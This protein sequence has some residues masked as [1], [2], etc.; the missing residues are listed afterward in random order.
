M[1]A[2]RALSVSLLFAIAISCT[3]S[4]PHVVPSPPTHSVSGSSTPRA[5]VLG[6]CP[7]TKRFSSLPVLARG[8]GAPDD[9]LSHPTLG[10]GL[11]VR[12]VDGSKVEVLFRDGTRTLIHGRK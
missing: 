11:V 5:S 7:A 8:L 2:V 1:N 6:A 4:T 3:N 9:L 12:I 10:A